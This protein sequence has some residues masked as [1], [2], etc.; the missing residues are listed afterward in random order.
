MLDNF[1]YQ[2]LI[3]DKANKRIDKTIYAHNGDSDGRGLEVQVVNNGVVENLTGCAL[4][5]GWSTKNNENYGLDAF[6]PVDAEKGIFRIKFTTGMTSNAGTLKA[7][8]QFVD[9]VS[10]TESFPFDMPVI[11]STIDPNAVQSENSFTALAEA[12]ITVSQY[13]IRI[14]QNEND[15]ADNRTDIDEIKSN[16]I[17]AS[18]VTEYPNL[19]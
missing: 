19:A 18:S 2:R 10:V 12:L 15:I 8:L 13:D 17:W 16:Y 6:E 9:G 14:V 3:W 5:L 4:N 11:P 1:K 7:V